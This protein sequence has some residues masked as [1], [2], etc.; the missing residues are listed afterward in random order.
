MKVALNR[1]ETDKENKRNF[2]LKQLKWNARQK[3]KKNRSKYIKKKR[4]KRINSCKAG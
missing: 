1:R 2:T 3:E 4:C